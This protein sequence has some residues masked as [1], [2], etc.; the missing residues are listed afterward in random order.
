MFQK[1]FTQRTRTLI[2]YGKVPGFKGIYTTKIKNDVDIMVTL[3][4]PDQGTC[5]QVSQIIGL[6][7]APYRTFMYL[8]DPERAGE[9][10]FWGF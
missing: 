2:I 4:I 1:F 8:V 7:Q 3:G 5:S 6:L 10:L 9:R